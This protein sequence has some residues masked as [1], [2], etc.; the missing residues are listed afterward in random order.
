MGGLFP[1]FNFYIM[2]A[3]VAAAAIGA[4]ATLGGT[5]ANI[6]S[7][8]KTNKVNERIA[9]QNREWQT[10][11]REAEQQWQLDQWNRE[12]AYNTPE[13][14][15]QL[16]ED[17]GYS[18]LAYL[19]GGIGSGEAGNLSSAPSAP[20]ASLPQM[21]NPGPDI[22]RG[23]SDASMQFLQWKSM[24]LA[25]KKIDNESRQTDADVNYKF[26]L[27]KTENECLQGRVD[28]LGAQFRWTEAKTDRDMQETK[29]AAQK[30]VESETEVKKMLQFIEES[31]VNVSLKEFQ[32]FAAQEKLPHEVKLLVQE[33]LMQTQSREWIVK[34]LKANYYGK[35]TENKMANDYYNLGADNG[36]KMSYFHSDLD[37]NSRQLYG[38]TKNPFLYNVDNAM[39][40]VDK[41]IE[42]AVSC[43]RGFMMYSVGRS[44]LSKMPNSQRNPIGFNVGM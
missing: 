10:S 16:L 27:T 24:Q 43:L 15:R 9:R 36:S 34:G 11:E 23:I 18:P 31:K 35:A 22:Q 5:A 32:K 37:S 17:A 8:N 7:T 25:E 38:R 4:A 3:T 20:S 21:Y 12:N 30:I 2:S 29:L 26:A 13:N 1:P 42:P 33:W 40:S 14:Q 6:Y 44:T 41:V 19:N 28:V 39:E